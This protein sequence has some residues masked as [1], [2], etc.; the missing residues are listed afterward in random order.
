MGTFKKLKEVRELVGELS[1]LETCKEFDLILE[2]GFNQEMGHPIC[3]KNLLLLE[4]ASA[5]TVRR[6]I[7]KLVR[8][9][10]IIR[11][12]CSDDRRSAEF[13]LSTVAE[14]SL[15]QTLGKITQLLNK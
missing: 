15:Q 9:G 7:E 12:V 4:L 5:A 14:D 13:T 10:T 3:L 8:N 1:G 2:I 6:C 11:Q